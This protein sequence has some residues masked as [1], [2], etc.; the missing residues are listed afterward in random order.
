MTSTESRRLRWGTTVR[1]ADIEEKQTK[2]STMVAGE[3]RWRSRDLGASLLLV[4]ARANT[5][6]DSCWTIE[7]SC[8]NVSKN[9]M[10]IFYG[11]SKADKK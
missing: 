2:G 1:D 10:S 11:L 3:K 9:I 6:A 4:Q 7:T 5:D 8:T